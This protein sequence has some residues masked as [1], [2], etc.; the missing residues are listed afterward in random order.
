MV[1]ENCR[2][3]TR[4]EAGVK[5]PRQSNIAS[6]APDDQLDVPAAFHFMRTWQVRRQDS[7]PEKE[8]GKFAAFFLGQLVALLAASSNAASFTLA[9]TFGIETQFFQMFGM[10]VLLSL[11]LR[12]NEHSS[13]SERRGALPH[14]LPGTNLQLH[15][16][17]WVYFCMSSMF[18][19]F[20]NFLVLL[21]LQY[22]SL[23]STTL[24]GSLSVPS[25]M[26]F[27][28]LILKKLFGCHHFIGVFLCVAGGLL[29]VWCDS[30]TLGS[31]KNDLTPSFV[32]TTPSDENSRNLLV[33]PNNTVGDICA[34]AAAVLY[35]LGDTVAEFSI[36]NIDRREYIGMIGLF[37]M[38]QTGFAVVTLERLS[39]VNGMGRLTQTE[40]LQAVC[41]VAWYTA[42]QYLYYVLEAYFLVSSDATLLNLSLQA[43]NLWVIL[44]SVAAF[45]RAPSTF[46]FAAVALVVV[47][48]F[49]YEDIIMFTGRSRNE[50]RRAEHERRGN[51]TGE[52]SIL[53]EHDGSGQQNSVHNYGGTLAV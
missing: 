9:T 19:V 13:I 10:Y 21:S 38:I 2:Y 43:S 17:W 11:H 4:P 26:L 40:L 50:R 8:R 18:D 1:N 36:K 47:G 46:F 20:P 23:T 39:L 44:F 41:V 30:T 48:V 16:P 15:L 49:I 35:G 31:T 29:T 51:R 5:R 32:Y 25:T 33:T 27:C 45:R 6:I 14:L 24:L 52:L 3:E 34:I 28:R 22:T 12:T 42:T 37:G 7:Q 53:V